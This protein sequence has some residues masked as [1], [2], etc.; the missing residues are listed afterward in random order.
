MPMRSQESLM[1]PLSKE[2]AKF[3][4]VFKVFADDGTHPSVALTKPVCV[5]GRRAVGVNLPLSAPEVSKL[6]AFVVRSQHHVYV[7]DLASRNGVQR[8]GAPVQE[9]G[10]SDED[11]LRIGSYTLRCA[12]GFGHAETS[13][14]ADDS[15]V[16]G[17][18]ADETETPL[19]AAELIG[20]GGATYPI[21]V[22]QHTFL[23]GHREGCDARFED[24]EQVAPVHAIVFEMDGKR[25]VRD[26]GAPGGTFLNGQSIHQSA[27]TPGDA[28]RI[29]SV[30]L[31]YALADAAAAE[32]DEEDED[33]AAARD[34]LGVNDSAPGIDLGGSSANSN[35]AM[36]ASLA[37]ADSMIVPEITMEDSHLPGASTP[38]REPS[39]ISEYDFDVVD[40]D[41]R[42][43]STFA[44][45]VVD[46]AE[47]AV[48]P[49]DAKPVRPER[50]PATTTPPPPTPA[51]PQR[52][53][54]D[55]V[56]PIAGS[57][58]DRLVD[59]DLLKD[60]AAGSQRSEAL[61]AREEE[62]PAPV[63]AAAQDTS[64]ESV[65]GD[66][67]IKVVIADEPHDAPVAAQPPPPRS[68]PPAPEPPRAAAAPPASEPPA[69]A[70]NGTA[71][72]EMIS[73]LVDE[74]TLRVGEVSEKV[75]LVAAKV[76]RVAAKMNEV[77]K[78]VA[79]VAETAG[80]LQ[81]VWS[82]YRGGAPQNSSAPAEKPATMKGADAAAADD[83]DDEKANPEERSADSRKNPAGKRPNS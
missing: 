44:G 30:T 80:T 35:L 22:G 36:N 77:T 13:G 28:I 39:A 2:V 52:G 79:E 65:A 31:R 66:A 71:A 14:A 50:P 1:P 72:E 67:P 60:V 18:S 63:T 24:D 15:I 78:D 38:G 5:I 58:H 37:T 4:P 69:P 64:S 48:T 51:A 55:S 10:L 16:A 29:G 19:P 53:M 3:L 74:V 61:P 70:G 82:D 42:R 25:Y 34:A 46:G 7:R 27:L 47:N 41:P 83:D 12:S 43:E 9:V 8:N 6:H 49:E 56:I 20:P 73:Q 76:E 45:E 17:A 40:S 81:E 68:A 11:V 62:K 32:S 33:A 26:L 23:I 54:D 57:F 59:D 21:P 75:E